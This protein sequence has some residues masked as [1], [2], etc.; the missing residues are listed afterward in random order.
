[1]G[2]FPPQSLSGIG[3]DG[4]HTTNKGDLIVTI[5]TTEQYWDCECRENFIHPA[6]VNHCPRCDTYRDEQPDSRVNE[7][8]DVGLSITAE[9]WDTLIDQV[10]D[11]AERFNE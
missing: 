11:A 1:M 3:I 2:G 10:E 5:K 4:R 6:A 9:N 7:V 8:L